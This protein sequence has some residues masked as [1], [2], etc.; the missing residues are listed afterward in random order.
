[1]LTAMIERSLLATHRLHAAHAR[2]KLRNFDIQF[3]VGRNP[4]IV[5]VRAQIVGTRYF[6][7]AHTAVRTGLERNSW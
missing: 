6:H 1:M 5:T 2:R 4:A 7:S 3:D